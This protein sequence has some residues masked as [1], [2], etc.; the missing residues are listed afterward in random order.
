L[1][2]IA[3]GSIFI[4]LAVITSEAREMSRNSKRIWPYS[5]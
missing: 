5:S 2:T 3:Y 1:L 4:R